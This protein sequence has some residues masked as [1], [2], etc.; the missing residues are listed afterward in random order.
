MVLGPMKKRMITSFFIGFFIMLLV[1]I[2]AVVIVYRQ[3]DLVLQ[4]KNSLE[5]DL[6]TVCVVANGVTIKAGEEI[7]SDKI[8]EKRINTNAIPENSFSSKS[9]LYDDVTRYAKI[10]IGENTILLSNMYYES[11]V[12]TDDLRIQE[13]NMILL[14]SQLENGDYVD[15]R[16]LL[17]TGNDY[18]VCSKKRVVDS[19]EGTIWLYL[20]ELDMQYISSATIESYVTEGSILYAIEYAEPTMQQAAKVTYPILPAVKNFITENPNLVEQV[21]IELSNRISNYTKD[22]ENLD[23]MSEDFKPEDAVPILTNNILQ[24]IE[25]QKAERAAMGNF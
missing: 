15:I 13:F 7:T 16:F 2:I 6:T 20:G 8:T 18:V 4:E 12:I 24:Q 14:P 25:R 5:R 19:T 10:D 23:E 17:P 22:R 3:Y 1:G 9:F 11:E 21:K